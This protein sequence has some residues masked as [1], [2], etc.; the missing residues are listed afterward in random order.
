MARYQCSACGYVYDEAAG[1]PR[2]GFPPG[3]KW[4]AIPEDWCCPDCA[5]REKPDFRELLEIDG[6]RP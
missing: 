3:T 1:A 5:V 4:S 6:V 2:A